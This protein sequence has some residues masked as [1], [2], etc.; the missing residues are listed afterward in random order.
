VSVLGDT[1]ALVTGASQGIGREIA[2]TFGGYG[3]QVVCAAR[4]GDAIEETADMV[5]EAGGEA[6]AVE[7]DVTD[8]DDVAAVV[9]ATVDEFGGLDCL[10]N[11]AGI[12]GPVDPVHRVDAD[13]FRYTQEVNVVGPFLCAKHAER[14]LRE[15]DRGSV[16]NIGSIGGKRPYPNR[17]VYAASKMALIGMTR[18]L[19]HELGRDGVTVNTVLPGPIEG[20]R[21]EE[22]VAKQAEIADVERAEPVDLGTDDFA[23]PDFLMDAAEVA[24]QVAYLASE[25]GRH[26]TAQEIGVDAGGTWY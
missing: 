10:V 13:E 25:R 11:N 14:H 7:T 1:I 8:E 9:E 4:S 21:L 26:V 5:A 16:V 22:V 15:S 18:T 3:A 23:L 20:P 12:G 19:A 6:V 24:E 17:L 2:G